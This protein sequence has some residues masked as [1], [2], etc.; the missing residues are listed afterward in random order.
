L[1]KEES[2]AIRTHDKPNEISCHHHKDVED[3]ANGA[4]VSIPGSIAIL[5]VGVF[6]GQNVRTVP[7]GGD[8]AMLVHTFEVGRKCLANNSGRINRLTSHPHA[9]SLNERS[10]QSATKVKIRMLEAATF[11]VPPKGT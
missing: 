5:E 11:L 1:P 9:K 4:D 6:Q 7:A 10:C 3:S 8:V 2:Y